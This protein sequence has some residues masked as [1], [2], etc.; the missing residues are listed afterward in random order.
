[1]CFSVSVNL[2]KEELEKRY[3]A[4]LIDHDKY[5]PS[6]YFHAFSFPSLPVVG[7]YDR[8]KME[9]MQWGLIPSWV[10]NRKSA[11]EIRLKTFNARA[12][13]VDEKPSFAGSFIS[14][15]CIVPVMGFF[16][17]QHVGDKKIP[18]YIF[19]ADKDIMSLAG[20]WSEWVDKSTGEVIKT[21]TIITTEAN[22]MMARIH[23]SK[24]RMP[25][26]LGKSSE[27]QWLNE[28]TPA[29]KIH[30]LMEPFPSEYLEAYTVSSKIGR[31]DICGDDPEILAP[32]KYNIPG[33]LF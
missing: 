16:E 17:W 29:E 28:K 3:N 5:R 10:R 4:L 27:E 7:G 18:W 15:R 19:R 31:K 21:F 13:T 8:R 32:H 20:L 22:E 23:N 24:K 9:M 30:K 6:Y 26:M 25:V 33:N 1:M 12:E 11:G 14:K 2:V